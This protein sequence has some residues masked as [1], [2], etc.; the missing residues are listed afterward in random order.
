M[1]LLHVNLKSKKEQIFFWRMYLKWN[2]LLS[3]HGDLKLDFNSQ[4]PRLLLA[5]L[6]GYDLNCSES[7]LKYDKM[8]SG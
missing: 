5:I 3:S 1:Q 8:Q 6:R 4:Q 2:R 7:L